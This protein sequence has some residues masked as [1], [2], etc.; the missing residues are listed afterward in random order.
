LGYYTQKINTVL[1]HIYRGGIQALGEYYYRVT[2]AFY[3]DVE[4]RVF[5]SDIKYSQKE[6]ERLLYM[7]VRRAVRELVKEMKK[8]PD[9][10]VGCEDIIKKVFKL[11]EEEG[12]RPIEYT[13]YFTLIGPNIIMPE[14]IEEVRKELKVHRWLLERIAKHNE[15]IE[16]E[17]LED[18]KA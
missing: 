17:V 4:S 13:A 11:L 1:K 2:W 14:D 12:F 10:Y 16:K 3:E 8:N 6:F 5:K 18:F 9:R 15:R 7:L